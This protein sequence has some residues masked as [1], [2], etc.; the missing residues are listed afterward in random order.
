MKSGM[1]PGQGTLWKI[2]CYALALVIGLP[3]NIEPLIHI[4][5]Y[6]HLLCVCVPGAHAEVGGYLGGVGFVLRHVCLS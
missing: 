5:L 1:L 4:Y 6:L 2:L 3:L